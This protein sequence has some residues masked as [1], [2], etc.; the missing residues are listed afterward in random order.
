[1]PLLSHL[2]LQF[3]SVPAHTRKDPMRKALVVPA[4]LTLAAC[5]SPYTPPAVLP[6]PADIRLSAPPERV[7]TAL[8]EVYTDL[9]LP[10]ENMDRSSWF[11]RSD[12]MTM[13]ASTT[14]A[15][16]FDCGTAP[17][18]QIPAAMSLNIRA[19]ITTLLR[20][21]GDQTAVRNRVNAVGS[22]PTP[23]SM[24]Y[25]C[26]SRGVLEKRITD[27]LTNRLPG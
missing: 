9:N 14:N 11:L 3:T 10:I 22:M 25:T 15:Q 23:G 1:M 6:D 20:P 16:L 17:G 2:W 5:G 18:G 24:T 27:A 8:T 21:N 4:L 13:P 19:S 7:W 12:E 26:Y